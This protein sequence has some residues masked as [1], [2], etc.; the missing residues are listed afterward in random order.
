L[1]SRKFVSAWWT[2]DFE[3]DVGPPNT[4][5]WAEL[6]RRNVSKASGVAYA[7]IA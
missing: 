2:P 5:F 6:K 1:A 4:S 7:V 3:S